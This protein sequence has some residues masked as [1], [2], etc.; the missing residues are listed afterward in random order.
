VDA[1]SVNVENL[2]G[3]L[4]GS[5]VPGSTVTLRV[6]KRIS[7]EIRDVEVVR[8]ESTELADKRRLFE[9]FTDIE[10]HIGNLPLW[11]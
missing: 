11:R 1:T 2:H 7:G 8:M 10:N 6:K 3:A 9:L 5:D 4:I